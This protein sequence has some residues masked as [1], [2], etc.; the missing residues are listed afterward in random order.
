M[1]GTSVMKELTSSGCLCSVKTVF[2]FALV[3]FE[4]IFD[5]VEDTDSI[6]SWLLDA[7]LLPGSRYFRGRNSNNAAIYI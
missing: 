1:I 2:S 3:S 5:Y 6:T 4:Y 7:T